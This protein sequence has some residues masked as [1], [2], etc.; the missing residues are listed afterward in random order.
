M[1]RP[2]GPLARMQ[3]WKYC[4]EE[5]K[6]FLGLTEIMHLEEIQVVQLKDITWMSRSELLSYH[7]RCDLWL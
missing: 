7:L 4:E 1:Q 2:K 5:I 3:I 6:K